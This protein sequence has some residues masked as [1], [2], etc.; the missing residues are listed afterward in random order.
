MDAPS[1]AHLLARL[2]F[3]EGDPAGAT[4]A[5]G[6][7]QAIR[8]AFDHG[9]TELRCLAEVLAERLGRTDYDSAYQQGARPDPTRGGCGLDDLGRRGG[10]QLPGVARDMFPGLRG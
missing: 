7:S 3:L 1:A 4:T 6:L 9:D 10:Q 5:L 2:L 8:R